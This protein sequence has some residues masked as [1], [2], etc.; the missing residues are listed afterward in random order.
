MHGDSL[1]A[2]ESSCLGIHENMLKTFSPLIKHSFFQDLP[3][4]WHHNPEHA[5]FCIPFF[6]KYK[7]PWSSWCNILLG[8]TE[9]ME[10][11]HSEHLRVSVAN[12][13]RTNLEVENVYLTFDCTF[14]I[15]LTDLQLGQDCRAHSESAPLSSRQ[16]S[17]REVV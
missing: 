14:P 15:I 8:Y 2:V 5:T 10:R 7:Q 6:Q 17:S 16:Y 3:F 11:A 9:Y 13:I 4:L 12:I 1:P